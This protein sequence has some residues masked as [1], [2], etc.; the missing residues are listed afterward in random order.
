MTDSAAP[1]RRW[2]VGLTIAA[3]I[4]LAILIGLGAW[5]LKRLAWK[6]DLLA[7]IAALQA[8]PAQPAEPALARMARGEELGFTRV[9]LDC[10]G[11]ARAPYVQ[12]Y[13]MRD[14]QAGVRLISACATPGQAYGA[15]LVDRGFVADTISARPPVDAA[16]RTPMRVQGV[17]RRPDKANFVTPRND[18][19]GNLWYSRDV[20]AMAKALGAGAPAPLMLLA[21]TSS[22]P[23]WKALTPAPL[24]SEIPNRHLEYA[25]TWFGLAG[26]LLAVYAA[27][28]W[29]RWK[30]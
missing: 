16:D 6:E 2:P 27:V 19:A 8:A 9:V 1:A 12:L 24:P 13:A 18:Q 21:E 3:A 4:G 5:Q 26:A 28:L 29:R 15:V 17:L 25:L 10:P 30:A 20:A 23:E 14:G 7:R 11:L 22:N